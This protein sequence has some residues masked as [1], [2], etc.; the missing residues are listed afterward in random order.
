MTSI[1]PLNERTFTCDPKKTT[2]P[3]AIIAEL[4]P[5]LVVTDSPLVSCTYL[6]RSERGRCVSH[7]IKP[8]CK[9]WIWLTG[10]IANV[11][12]RIRQF[13]CRPGLASFVHRM[14]M[15]DPVGF[16]Q[17]QRIVVLAHA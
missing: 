5:F 16:G 11:N 1:S 14:R 3:R 15:I 12:C 10:R 8:M 4:N 9:S 6:R 17:S 2:S 13:Q 7:A